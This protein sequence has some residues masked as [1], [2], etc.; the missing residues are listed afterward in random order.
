MT[1]R[2][3]APWHSR[4]AAATVG[5]HRVGEADQSERLESNRAGDAGQRRRG[6]SRARHPGRGSVR[7]DARGLR[8]AARFEVLVVQRQKPAT[9]SGAPFVATT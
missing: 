6:T 8:D 3:P 2:M 5:P 7:G 9:A 4:T 1:T